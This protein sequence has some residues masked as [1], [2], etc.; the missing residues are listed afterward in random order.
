M[1]MHI[2]KV[3]LQTMMKDGA[4]HYSGLEEAVY[5][6]INACKEIA[7]IIR[8]SFG[9]NGM[10]KMIVDHLDKLF[11]TNDAATIIQKLDVEHPAAKMVIDASGQQEHEA[12]D[13]T[14]FVII[15][16]GKMLE[17]AEHL[18]RMGVAVADVIAG[19]EMACE[20]AQEILETLVCHTV[21][22][23]RDVETVAQAL[24]TCIGSKQAGLEQ[25]IAKLVAEACLRILPKETTR[26]PFNVDNVRVCK[27]LGSGVTSSTVLRGM[28]F[29]RGAAG[30]V[31]SAENA[32]MA[33]YTADVDYGFTETKG[34]VLINSADE[35]KQYSINE[36]QLLEQNIKGIKDAGV[37]VIVT[38]GKIGDMAL[39]FCN[40][41]DIMV[42]KTNSKFELKR[43]CRATRTTA[44]P[45]FSPPAPS[46]IGHCDHVELKE[47][48]DTTV[49]I[50]RQDD[51]QSAVSTI[52][53]RGATANIMDDVERAID[54]GV[55]N[56]KALTQDGRF[57]PGAGAAEIELAL[58][59]SSFGDTC[60]GLEQY[61]IKAFAEALEVVPQTLAENAGVK[62]KEL[63]SKL[64]AAH[65]G[66]NKN[67]GFDNDT[68]SSEDI[69]DV[70]AAN[71][72]DLYHTKRWGITYAT[73][74]ACTVL[75][76][77]QIIMAKRAGGPKPPKQGNYDED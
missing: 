23:P 52:V 63:V 2:P 27:V 24:E 18:L 51:V 55:N 25:F 15:L 13:G 76:V 48:G 56:Y 43:L 77:D 16:A 40:R 49:T 9:P 58:Q 26:L 38:S 10:N 22:D 17:K 19:F 6:N 44:L 35:L 61:A 41:M 31:S 12:G 68:D 3:G 64:Y 36:E 33:V 47:I 62:P 67:A 71:I 69:K 21:E 14:N 54:D 60:A 50:F 11:V 34:T 75:R 59:L 39:H 37:D 29:T 66:G 4:K 74:A 46:E 30:V 8:S 1:A 28:V 57:V 65:Q 70:V 42:V 20:K 72:L 73:Q 53:I 7:N 45:R 5:R 32:R